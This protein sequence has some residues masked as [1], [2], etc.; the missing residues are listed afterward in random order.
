MT[1]IGGDKPLS[2]PPAVP[3]RKGEEGKEERYRKRRRGKQQDKNQSV[4]EGEGVKE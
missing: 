3:G 4:G 2:P 1:R